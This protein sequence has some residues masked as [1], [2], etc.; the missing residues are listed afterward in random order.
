MIL[1]SPLKIIFAGTPVFAAVALQ[2][3]LES[4]NQVIAIYTQPDRPA[5]RGQKLTASPVKE[6]ALRYHLPI[7]QPVSLR[8]AHE[9]EILLHM[10]PDVIIVAA[11]GLM[12]P[13]AILQIP[14]LGCVNIHASLLPRWRGAAPIQRAI[15]AGDE[16]T[17]VTIMQMEEGL[18]TGPM[19]YKVECSIQLRDT[20]ET[21]HNRLAGLGADAILATLNQLPY[22]KPEAQN[23]ALATYASKIT[24][25]EARLDWHSSADELARKIRAFNPWPVACIQNGEQVIRLWEA[26]VIEKDMSQYQPGEILQ[27]NANGIDIATK[28]NALRLLKIQ[29][30]GGRV[31]SVADILNARQSDFTAG[32]IL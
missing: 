26:T 29:L 27:A 31:L 12:L 18:D 30:P 21:I 8:H 14:R 13:P 3:L 9:Q 22:L 20:S 4:S 1:T 19:L 10:Q 16:K 6:L 24:K 2:A 15:L 17:G 25:E 5:G 28:K 7:H 32:K 11:Y 23:A